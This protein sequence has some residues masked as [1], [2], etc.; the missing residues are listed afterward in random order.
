MVATVRAE[1]REVWDGLDDHLAAMSQ[2][3]QEAQDALDAGDLALFRKKRMAHLM[4]SRRYAKDVAEYT[5]LIGQA[6]EN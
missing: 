1:L 3:V 6:D 5:A 2:A 4:A